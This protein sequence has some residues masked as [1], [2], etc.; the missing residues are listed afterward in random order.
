[1]HIVIIYEY[2][3]EEALEYFLE[4]VF[5]GETLVFDVIHAECCFSRDA[6]F[7]LKSVEHLSKEVLSAVHQVLSDD[8]V[9]PEGVVDFFS[10]VE[11]GFGSILNLLVKL[12]DL[13]EVEELFKRDRAV[14]ILVQGS[15]YFEKFSFGEGSVKEHQPGYEVSDNDLFTLLVLLEDRVEDVFDVEAGVLLED[16]LEDLFQVHN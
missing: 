10:L 15:E 6:M 9:G 16:V 7:L 11:S 2:R 3:A 4:M 14:S 8:P 1:L 13:N 12:G 5:L